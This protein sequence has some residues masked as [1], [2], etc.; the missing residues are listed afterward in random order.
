MPSIILKTNKMSIEGQKIIIVILAVAVLLG[1]L[2]SWPRVS[3]A[4]SDLRDSR[5]NVDNTQLIGGFQKQ[6]GKHESFLPLILQPDPFIFDTA[7]W[8]H[9]EKPA[10]HEIA[11]FRHQF[12]LN[13]EFNSAALNIFADTRYE[14]WIDGKWIGRGPA[15]FTKDLHEYDVYSLNYLTAG[16]HVIAVLVQ[17]APNYRR[18]VSTT[19]HLKAHISGSTDHGNFIVARTGDGWRGSISDAWRYDSP[20]IHIWDLIGPTELMD[21][22]QFDPDWIEVEFPDGEWGLAQE[23]N[24]AKYSY[25]PLLVPRLDSYE[26][27]L[28]DTFVKPTK[29]RENITLP[30]QITYQPRTISLLTDIEMSA[31]IREYGSLSP[32]YLI[33][34]L[35]QPVPDP[36][37]LKFN[38]AAQVTIFVETLQGENTGVGQIKIDN[39]VL[40]WEAWGENR[41]DVYISQASVESGEH[42]LVFEDIPQNGL[43]FAV[44]NN[45]NFVKFPF[46]QGS[47]AGRRLLLANPI[48]HSEEVGTALTSDDGLQIHFDSPPSYA[49]L[50]LGRTVHGRLQAQV[51]GPNGSVLD[52]GWDERLLEG[53][54]RPLPFPGSLHP[55]WNQ[56]DSWTLDG[57]SRSITTIDS[58]AGRYVLVAAWGTGPITLN[59]IR[60]YEERYP[61]SQTGNF[62]SSEPLLDII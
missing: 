26:D 57:S 28:Y 2:F 39:H 52:I 7:I 27:A 3:R 22:R 13:D 51:S 49:I 45:I 19:P 34:D 61:V 31:R 46:E 35:S 48:K 21:L 47:N 1:N 59:N 62:S 25:E 36:Y 50:D 53:T 42:S 20:P 24:P 8:P 15:R 44:S 33:G 38:A 9:N 17:W 6:A 4:E 40:S 18:S 58:R 29:Q 23:V 11:L 30:T 60:V 14:V 32:G 41:P 10:N 12:D 43:T 16:S 55:R 56:V 54:N 37:T 5:K